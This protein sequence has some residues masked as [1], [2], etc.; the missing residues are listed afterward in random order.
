[1]GIFHPGVKVRI[2]I[3]QFN[4]LESR[5]LIADVHVL[6]SMDKVVIVPRE[7]SDRVPLRAAL[8]AALKGASLSTSNGSVVLKL[9]DACELLRK[10]ID[11]ELKWTPEARQFIKN[12]SKVQRNYPIVKRTIDAL[13]E[14][15][16]SLAESMLE[17]ID[18][19]ILD[20]HQ[21][22]NV[23]AMTIPGGFGLCLFDEQG[24]GKTVTT[25][26][27]YDV[28]VERNEVDIALIVA[29]KSMVGEWP[30]D[31][32]RF[33]SD[34][35]KVATVTGDLRHKRVALSSGA[36]IFVTNYETTINLEAELTALLR[37][38]R[39]RSILVVDESFFVKNRDAKRTQSLRR[40]REWCERAYV[41]CG[42]PAPNAPSDLVEQFNLVDMG[43]TFNSVEI[44]DNRKKAIPVV[45]Q[46]INEYGIYI[47]HL[48][49][50]VLSDLPSKRFN[51]VL[52]PLAQQQNEIYIEALKGY[53]KELRSTNE[54]TFKKR[55]THFL[56][57]RTVLLQICSNPSSLVADYM[58]IPAKLLALDDILE[59]IISRKGEK[60]VLWSFY[61]NSIETMVNRYEMYKPVRYDGTVS[62]VEDRQKAVRQFQEDPS[63]MLFIGNPAAAGAGLTLHRSRYAIYESFSDQAAH[64]LQ[65]LDR[66]HRK[67]QEREVDYII[68]LANQTLEVKQYETLQLKERSAH[69]LLNDNIVELPSKTILLS[70]AVS[71]AKALC[72]EM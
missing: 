24:T 15:G 1:M 3:L 51:T 16:R 50:D 21:I 23:A 34:H 11:L 69:D 39:G 4:N 70:E 2:I 57:Q 26:Y 30:K 71:A 67:G 37:R 25:I 17:G 12:R 58:E 29:P 38:Y 63:V 20:S 27:A 62:S 9:N 36:D 10:T 42:T 18:V 28:L 7:K 54:E 65:S 59:E 45:R 6:S 47:R 53:I 13:K 22:V 61:R 33:K 52:V 41:L 56:A 72:I 8:R 46:A 68:L 32:K 35:Y 19:S 14:K 48:K 55:I 43:V 40:L 5:S 64:Y 66:I 49:Q 44:P 31:I 60:V